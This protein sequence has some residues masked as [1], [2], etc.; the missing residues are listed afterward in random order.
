MQYS[1]LVSLLHDGPYSNSVVIMF[2]KLV[3]S[4]SDMY[5]SSPYMDSN[6]DS[7]PVFW[8]GLDFGLDPSD[9]NVYLGDLEFDVFCNVK[10]WTIR[11]EGVKFNSIQFN[12]DFIQSGICNKSTAM[13]HIESWNWPIDK[14]INK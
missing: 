10:L 13:L 4:S 12:F 6:P 2:V 14:K 7:N 5:D 3:N 9:L 1:Y 11:L 8:L